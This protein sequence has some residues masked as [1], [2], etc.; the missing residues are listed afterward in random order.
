MRPHSGVIGGRIA[1]SGG[2][3]L[4]IAPMRGLCKGLIQGER[5]LRTRRE[6]VLRTGRDAPV[7]PAKAGISYPNPGAALAYLPTANSAL[8]ISPSPLTYCPVRTEETG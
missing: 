5:T 3:E 2:A 7:I 8:H 6:R 4:L 1:C